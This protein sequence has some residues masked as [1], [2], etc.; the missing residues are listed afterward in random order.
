MLIYTA[1]GEA[2]DP[3]DLVSVAN[4]K[5]R[6]PITGAGE[7]RLNGLVELRYK[8]GTALFLRGYSIDIIK[9]IQAQN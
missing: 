8:N 6:N 9:S 3:T 7:W 5:I 2:F 1:D 4:V